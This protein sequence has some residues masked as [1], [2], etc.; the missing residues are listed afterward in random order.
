MTY[1]QMKKVLYIEFN[2]RFAKKDLAQLHVLLPYIVD[3][4]LLQDVAMHYIVTT[5]KTIS[6][7]MIFELRTIEENKKSV[8]YYIF[9]R[10]DTY[11]DV[12]LHSCS[13]EFS[14]SKCILMHSDK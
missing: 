8:E 1:E 3:F 12:P 7:D 4:D 6:N 13:W 11:H 5:L 14:D 9:A 10:E 2:N